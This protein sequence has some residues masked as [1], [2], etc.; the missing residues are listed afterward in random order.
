[1]IIR[2]LFIIIFIFSCKTEPIRQQIEVG[3]TIKVQPS[4][5]SINDKD[6]VFLW[7]SPNGPP[8]SKPIYSIENN[9]MLFTP[10]I[11]GNYEIS[12]MIESA[13]NNSIYEETFLFN[14]T[15]VSKNTNK[16]IKEINLTQ[17]K[18][19]N[20]S[21]HKFT[22]QVASW[23]TLEQARLDQIDLRESG[24]DA[25]TEQYYIKSKDQLWWRVRVG[26]FSDKSIAIE[27][28][29]KLSKDRGNDLWIDFI[30]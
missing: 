30:N 4:N 18:K 6:L 22:I 11:S 24:Y 26:N 25:Y 13:N 2:L 3:K 10:D 5:F 27:V 23:P 28:K 20:K 15:G 17:T 14:A 1:M 9:K 12:L 21:N 8:N 19:S 7:S 29:N 16:S